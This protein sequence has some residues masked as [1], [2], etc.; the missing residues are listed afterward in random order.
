MIETFAYSLDNV[1]GNQ[2]GLVILRPLHFQDKHFLFVIVVD[3]KKINGGLI[4][5]LQWEIMTSIDFFVVEINIH[6]M[7]VGENT[8]DLV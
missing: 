7:P 4:K 5:L 3:L 1:L 2:Y 8:S 6:Q